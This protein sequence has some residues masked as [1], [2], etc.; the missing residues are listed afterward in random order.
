[1]LFVMEI[2]SHSLT[3]S[4]TFYFLQFTHFKISNADTYVKININLLWL[5]LFPRHNS[6]HMVQYY[7]SA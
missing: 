3:Y 4:E 6:K 1:M 5:Q 7:K 2:G